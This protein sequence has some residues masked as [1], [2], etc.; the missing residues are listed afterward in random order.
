M[1]G[2]HRS[3]SARNTGLYLAVVVSLGVFFL[4]R[5]GGVWGVVCLKVFVVY[6]GLNMLSHLSVSTCRSNHDTCHFVQN[7]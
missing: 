2:S 5:G 6:A 1:S 3:L 7:I 4:L